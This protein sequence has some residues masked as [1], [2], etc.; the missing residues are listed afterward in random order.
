MSDAE[1]R[2]NDD[3]V[4]VKE[5]VKDSI[6]EEDWSNS[7]TQQVSGRDY[8]PIPDKR[9]MRRLGKRQELKVGTLAVP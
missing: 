7:E 3:D 5:S 4:S 1:A 8:D 9:D 2:H 6:K